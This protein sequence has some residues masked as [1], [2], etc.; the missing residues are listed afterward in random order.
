MTLLK[1][2]SYWLPALLW[3]SII[4]YLSSKQSPTHS[5]ILAWLGHLIEYSTLAFLLMIALTAT[6]KLTRRR[7]ILAAAFIAIFYGATDEV[8]QLFVPGRFAD[9][10]DLYMDGLGAIVGITFFV[11]FNAFLGRLFN[12]KY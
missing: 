1:K 12:R 4:F 11:A 3:M 5:N 9:L 6:V 10:S 8:H 7:L 2:A